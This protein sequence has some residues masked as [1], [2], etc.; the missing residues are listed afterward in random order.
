MKT[1][2][3]LITLISL[4]L[5]SCLKDKG[6]YDYVDI[7]EIAFKGIASS[8]NVMM[9][10]DTIRI[11]PEIIMT[12]GDVNDTG[13]F[14]YAWLAVKAYQ[15]KDTL[16]KTKKL[17]YPVKLKPDTYQF[18]LKI[19]DKK[20]EVIWIATSSLV[21]GTAY[22]KG[23][24][25]VGED[26][27]GYVKAQMLSM[28]K[29]TILFP[30][31]LKDNGLPQLT[32]AV[33]ILHTGYSGTD[34]N[35]KLWLLTTSGSYF[36]DRLTQ[37]ATTANNFKSSVYTADPITEDLTPVV[38]APRI[39]DKAGNN[40]GNS[41]RAAIC[42][43]GM[44]FNSSLTLLGGDYYT[45]P[46]NRLASDFNTLLKAK[47]YMLYSLNTWSGFLWY[48]EQNERFLRVGPFESTSSLLSDIP[49]DIFPWNQAGTGRTL[50]YGENTLNTDGGSTAGNSFAIMK[51]AA[52]QTYIYKFY[53]STGTEKRGIYKVK[54]IAIGFADAEFYAFS[55]KRTV[56]FYVKNNVLY[57]Y[58]YNTG[59]EKC[60]TIQNVGTDPIT[61]LKF[62]TQIDPSTNPL[63]IATYNSTTGGTL[64]KY[65]LG[66]SPDN[67]TIS[68]DPKSNWTGL[69]KIKN[70]SWRAAK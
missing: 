33:D 41:Y 2:I 43:N 46:V 31:M 65:L 45:N 51:D 40:G 35:I 14:E 19:R 39:K 61:M 7:N 66:S 29:D 67:I 42:K 8:Y 12:D 20:T 4:V 68:A 56:V 52:G 1:K 48:D 11:D 22:S 10:F 60:F 28:V 70:M 26:K 69:M 64:K 59:N 15:S 21:V 34:K 5:S 3:F 44:V 47:P 23:I 24:M 32:G 30:D 50:I 63:Y 6:N 58:D 18:F 53:V 49:G 13:R 25:L 9:D 17:V 57:A 36:I 37:K 54:D 27:Q 16:S 62:D 55:S 38:I